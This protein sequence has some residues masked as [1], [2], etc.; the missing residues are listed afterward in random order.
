MTTREAFE[1]LIKQKKWY[2]L[3]GI[4]QSDATSLKYNLKKNLVTKKRMSELCQA[5]GLF[6]YKPEKFELKK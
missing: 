4:S 2:L 5:S 3:C 6:K 1:H